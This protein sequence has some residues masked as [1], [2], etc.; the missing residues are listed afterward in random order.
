MCKGIVDND[1]ESVTLSAHFA[2]LRSMATNCLEGQSAEL[3]I[4][5]LDFK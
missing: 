3:V 2:G 1:A 4:V 5:Q